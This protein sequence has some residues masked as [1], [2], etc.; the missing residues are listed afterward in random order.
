M[1]MLTKEYEAIAN[2]RIELG[3]TGLLRPDVKVGMVAIDNSPRARLVAAAYVI[4]AEAHRA[5]AK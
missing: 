1:M 2:A 5:G 3:K 4:L